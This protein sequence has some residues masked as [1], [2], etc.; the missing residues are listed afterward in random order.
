MCCLCS[1]PLFQGQSELG[2]AAEQGWPSLL[3]CEIGAGCD[4]SRPCDEWV[5]VNVGGK[6]AGREGEMR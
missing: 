3:S 5:P 4:I 6:Q 1:L 2:F